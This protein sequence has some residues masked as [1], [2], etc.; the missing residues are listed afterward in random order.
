MITLIL[1]ALVIGIGGTACID[2]WAMFLRKAFGIQSLSYCFLGRWILHM[3]RGRFVHDAIATSEARPR[4]CTVGWA[5]HYSIGVAFAA[6]FLWIAPRTWL[7]H[8]TPVPALAFGMVTVAVPFLTMQ[9]AFGLGIAASRTKSPSAARLKSLATHTIF[10][11]GM[12]AV[13]SLM[14]LWLFHRAA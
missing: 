9:P 4:E 8:P 11:A 5:A 7:A 6:L 10:G 3:P 2:L 1:G 13:A 14:N 12:Y